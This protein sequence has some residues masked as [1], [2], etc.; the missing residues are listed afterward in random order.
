M[1]RG[2]NRS[3]EAGEPR[4]LTPEAECDAIDARLD[5]MLAAGEKLPPDFF[6]L[7]LKA[8]VLAK[9]TYD[10]EPAKNMKYHL[11][12]ILGEARQDK[13]EEAEEAIIKLDWAFLAL[14]SQHNREVI[15]DF[16]IQEYNKL[17]REYSEQGQVARGVELSPEL[18]QHLAWMLDTVQIPYDVGTEA[19][20]IPFAPLEQTMRLVAPAWEDDWRPDPFHPDHEKRAPV[21][22]LMEEWK[23]NQG[24]QEG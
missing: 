23:Q 11:R 3:S 2:E 22:G 14:A 10:F 1:E 24:N 21:N 20:C 12:N 18:T 7:T 19:I 4:P 15:T 8:R 17:Q 5:E 9:R 13:N 16:D 6:L